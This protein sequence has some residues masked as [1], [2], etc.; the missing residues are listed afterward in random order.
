MRDTTRGEFSHLL[1]A[2][3]EEIH[4]NLQEQTCAKEQKDYFKDTSLNLIT[5]VVF[6]ILKYIKRLKVSLL[7]CIWIKKHKVK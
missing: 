6:R 1:R 7:F 5:E 2:K 3:T 4:K